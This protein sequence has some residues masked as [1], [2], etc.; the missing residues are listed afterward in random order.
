MLELTKTPPTEFLHVSCPADRLE[1]IINFL[2]DNGCTVSEDED[3]LPAEEVCDFRPST[4]LRGARGKEEMTQVELSR[5][6]GISVRR[7]RDMENDRRP[8][9]EATAKVLGRALNIGYNV[10]L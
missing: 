10:F 8:I 1:R 4:I 9:D 2:R 3:Y 6:T 5:R 7:I